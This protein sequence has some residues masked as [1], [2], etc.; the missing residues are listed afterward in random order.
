MTDFKRCPNCSF[1]WQNRTD[2]MADDN[3]T[4]IGYQVLYKSLKEGFFLFN[5]SCNGTF[6]VN[7]DSFVDLYDG[8]VFEEN[9]AGTEACSGHCLHKQSLSPCPAK[10]ECAFVREIIQILKE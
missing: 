7:V 1:V 3:V 5:H 9:L 4:I 6:A 8:P 10:C 2:F